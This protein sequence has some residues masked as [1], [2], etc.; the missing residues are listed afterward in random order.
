MNAY[1]LRNN[2]K[3]SHNVAVADS[4]LKR[5]KGLLGRN[6]MLQGEALLIKP[7]MSIH[8]FLMKFPID[9][10]FLDKRSRV[11]AAIRNL[12]PNRLTALYLRAT[13]A[14][15]LPAGILDATDT[16]VGD[17]IEIEIT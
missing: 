2:R 13:S 5:L 11:I 17:E 6:E 16:K 10:I 3:L 14:L 15:E 8:T 12:Q 9:V 4:L 1:N 7:C